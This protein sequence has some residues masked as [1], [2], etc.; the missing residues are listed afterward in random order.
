MSTLSLFVSTA[1]LLISSL[2]QADP[3]SVHGMLLFG[4]QSDYASH[5]PMFHSPHDYQLILKL[6]L[7]DAP[8]AGVLATYRSHQARGETLFTIEPEVMDLTQVINGDKKTFRAQLYLGHFERGGKPIGKIQVG[9]EK[10]VFSSKL[11][12][13]SPATRFH[14]HLLFGQDGEYFVAHLIQG[15]PSFDLIASAS[16]PSLPDSALP[17]TLRTL[18]TDGIPHEGSALQG[19]S[20]Q[21]M[22]TVQKVLYLEE[23]ELSH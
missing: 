8:G 5:L 14:E 2:A 6:K 23:A 19:S 10:I 18:S 1:A 9:V 20:G 15:K 16:R 21:T 7:T 11:K 12:P 3:P 4:N 22:S 17:A 13:S